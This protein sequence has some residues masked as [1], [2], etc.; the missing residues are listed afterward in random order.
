M[1]IDPLVLLEYAALAPSMLWTLG[2]WGIAMGSRKARRAF[3]G[4]GYLRP[5]SGKAWLRFLY[6]K[7]YEAF[8]DPSIRSFYRLAHICLFLFV[9][10]VIV[11]G[12][13][14]GSVVLLSKVSSGPSLQSDSP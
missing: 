11:L 2:L 7:H 4:K 12:I 9:V 5:P 10:L 13:F 8:E 6:Y 14:L 3:R 1:L